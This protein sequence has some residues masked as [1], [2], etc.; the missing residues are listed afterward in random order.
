M[1]VVLLIKDAENAQQ[2]LV[3][4]ATQHV[5]IAKWLPGALALGLDWVDLMETGYSVTDENRVDVVR[6]LEMLRNWMKDELEIKRLD[7]LVVELRDLQFEKGATA[8][9]G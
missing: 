4:I 3:P 6:E 1:S 7:R 8:F 5:F 2:R 9:L